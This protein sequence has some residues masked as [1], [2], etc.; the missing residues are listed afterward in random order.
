MSISVK[1]QSFHAIV[2]MHRSGTT[3]LGHILQRYPSLQVIHEPLNQGYGFAGIAQVYPTDFDPCQCERY[4]GLL[5]QALTGTASFVKNVDED[6][7]SKAF[8]RRLIG[9]R[10]GKDLAVFKF[11][12]ILNSGTTPVFK[13]PFCTLL[14]SAFL[15]R[16]HRVV[17]LVRHPAAVWLS[18]R[19]MGWTFD[20]ESFACNEIFEELGIQVS[21]ADLQGRAEIEKFAY[22]WLALYS[23]L[24]RLK[25]CPGLMLI[26]H[27]SFCQDPYGALAG[28]EKFLDLPHSQKVNTD[29]NKLHVFK[30]DS[31]K[32]ASSWVDRMI[33]QDE[34]ILRSICGEI[35]D[36]YYGKWMPF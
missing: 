10:T 34:V 19:R 22:L 11:V 20:F 7:L 36:K 18:I 25:S 35:V 15:E 27:E 6:S 26:K 9:G 31:R 8:L 28:L 33:P 12:K 17:A 13:D 21:V 24:D 16:G 23:Y 4:L 2:G 32:L 30:R 14:T 29:S 1:A 5:E 3:L